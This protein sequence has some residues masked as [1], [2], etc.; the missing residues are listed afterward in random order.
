MGLGCDV[1]RCDGMGLGCDGDEMG[2]G[3]GYGGIGM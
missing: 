2:L 3:L 1:I